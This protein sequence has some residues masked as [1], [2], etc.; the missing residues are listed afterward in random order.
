MIDW[1]APWLRTRTLSR[2]WR[3]TIAAL[4]AALTVA[5]L[6]LPEAHAES[7]AVSFTASTHDAAGAFMGGTELRNL[8]ACHGRLY[9]G[10]G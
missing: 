1:R 9:A 8:V 6:V 5:A 7:A 2:R 4:A 3:R 10:N